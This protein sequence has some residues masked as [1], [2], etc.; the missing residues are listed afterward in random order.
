M[1]APGG[2]GRRDVAGGNSTRDEEISRR[3]Y[4]IY[5]ERGEQPGTELEDW[6][7]AERELQHGVISHAQAGWKAEAMT[8]VVN[9]E[10]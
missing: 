3:A 6:L 7:Q 9:D 4:E 2:E 5:L 1:E 8:S 10:R